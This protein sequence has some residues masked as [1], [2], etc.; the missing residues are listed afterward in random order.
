MMGDMALKMVSSRQHLGV[1]IREKSKIIE[2]Y[3]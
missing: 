1:L 3:F 2:I